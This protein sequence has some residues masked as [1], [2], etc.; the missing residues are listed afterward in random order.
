MQCDFIGTTEW[1]WACVAFPA[2]QIRTQITTWFAL[3]LAGF[4]FLKQVRVLLRGII[5]CTSVVL[6]ALKSPPSLDNH[7]VYHFEN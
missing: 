1:T 4:F 5:R 3:V 7:F 6:L 2:A